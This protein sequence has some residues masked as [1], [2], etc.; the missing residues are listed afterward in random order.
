MRAVM[1]ALALSAASTTAISGVEAARPPDGRD[2]G[3]RGA[4][5]PLPMLQARIGSIASDVWP[6]LEGKLITAAPSDIA[7]S[8]LAPPI[9]VPA[10]A[11]RKPRSCLE[12]AVAG[13]HA[14]RWSAGAVRISR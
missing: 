9:G 7:I 13:R 14:W 3:G 6:L 10:G 1:I 4:C 2:A 8:R 11:P 5:C 12:L